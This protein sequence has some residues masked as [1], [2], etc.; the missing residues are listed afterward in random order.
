MCI[1]S[2]M[3]ETQFGMTEW[4]EVLDEAGL[5]G[6]YTSSALYSDDEL[7]TLVSIISE[8][9]HVP[10]DDLIFAF[11]QHL[12][13]AFSSRYPKLISPYDNLFDFLE[14]IDS[15]IHVEVKKLHPDAITPLFLHER[16]SDRRLKLEYRSERQ[17]CTLA[18]GL[19]DGAAEHFKQAYDLVHEPCLHHGAD[20]CGFLINLK[21]V[22]DD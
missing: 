7:L 5:T 4:N 8:R 13:P 1:L 19:I 2:E 10:V 11:G 3:V 9:N 20:H 22:D 21:S 14:C 16:L 6:V 15:V 18:L 17:F 12:F